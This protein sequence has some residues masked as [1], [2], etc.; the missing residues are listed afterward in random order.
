MKIMKTNTKAS[1]LTRL[2]GA[3]IG[4]LIGTIANAT[5][6]S[7]VT[8]T[9]GQLFID[10]PDGDQNIK[11]LVGS[12]PGQTQVFGV[13]GL[14]DGIAYTGVR[15][16][17]L[18]TGA[19]F[20]KVEFDVVSAQ[21]L[22]ISSDTAVGQAETKVQWKVA[23]GTA[24]SIN[25]LALRSA[26]G[27]T[28]AELDFTS[29]AQNTEFTWTANSGTGNAEVKGGI[30]FKAPGR[31]GIGNV[32]FNLGEGNHLVSVEVDSE[33]RNTTLNIDAGN[34]AET[35]VK[36]VS[37]DPSD[38]LGLTFNA[39]APKTVLE[40][41][42]SAAICNMD[43]TGTHLSAFNEMKYGLSQIR[44]GKVSA[45]Y[46]LQTA[47]GGDKIEANIS[48]PGSKVVL[49]GSVRTGAGDD[50][51]HFNSSALSTVVGLDL[52]RWRW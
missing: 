11:F 16:I 4:L 39:R 19:D 26:V 27:A 32:G 13:P 48:A 3:I 29:E 21:S 12:N 28:K 24:R 6:Q 7:T 34:A 46:D 40:M 31:R 2:N 43:V 51:T 5:G 15:A 14:A 44:P 50:F 18:V 20:D 9:N 1:T 23:P 35:N 10:T 37:D 33:V 8:F 25:S 22:A 42:S 41:I 52:T 38:F 45:F 30:D 36:V 47:A 49:D 17:N